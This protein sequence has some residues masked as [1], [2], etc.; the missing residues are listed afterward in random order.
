MAAKAA[1]QRTT[2]NVG[3]KTSRFGQRTR[4]P[5]LTTSFVYLIGFIVVSFTYFLYEGYAFHNACSTYSIQ[6]WLS[7]LYFYIQRSFYLDIHC[8]SK[9]PFPYPY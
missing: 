6:A 9:K 1:M 8:K 4:L 7:C 3:N 5:S 2:T